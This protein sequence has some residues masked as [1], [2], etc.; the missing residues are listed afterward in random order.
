MLASR[1]RIFFLLSTTQSK[2]NS[3]LVASLYSIF[4]LVLPTRLCRGNFTSCRNNHRDVRQL[5]KI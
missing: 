1:Y 3:A 4:Y 5:F 2:Q